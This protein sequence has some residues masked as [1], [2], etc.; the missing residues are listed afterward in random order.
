MPCRPPVRAMPRK[1][2]VVLS[3]VVHLP[4]LAIRDVQLARLAYGERG[5]WTLDTRR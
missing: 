1:F 4:H 3:D 2:I 5:R